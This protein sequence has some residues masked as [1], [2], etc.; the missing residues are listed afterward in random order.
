[1]STEDME[2]NN[3][4]NKT[5]RTWPRFLVIQSTNDTN[6]AKTSPFLI[7]K[8][9]AGLAG[10]PKSVKKMRNG[11][12]LVECAKESHASSLLKSTTL[13]NIPIKVAPHNSLNSSRGVIRSQ[14]LEGS[15]EEEMLENLASQGVTY[16]KRISI[17]RNGN[18]I[19]TNTYILTFDKP[20]LP[21]MIKAGFLA[22]TV[23]PYIPNPLRCFHC[24]RFGHS[25][26]VCKGKATCARCGQ[27]GHESTSCQLDHCCINCKGSHF[28]Y[29][30]ECP[31]WKKE[32]QVQ[33]VKTEKN[34][35]YPEARKLVEAATPTFA[36][37]FANAVKP[38]TASIACQTPA[39]FPATTESS[40][41]KK[42]PIPPKPVNV[43]LSTQ[44][45]NKSGETENEEIVPPTPQPNGGNPPKANKTKERSDKDASRKLNTFRSRKGDEDPVG[46]YNRFG[47]QDNLMDVV[48]EVHDPKQ[49]HRSPVKPP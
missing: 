9:L 34:I 42:P 36:M 11:T 23:T 38:K 18:I 49:H 15:S 41:Q 5:S 2:I 16:V 27:D 39:E 12:L 30:R 7:S 25:K 43:S 37:S 8:G 47:I 45:A 21:K 28:A 13:A 3:I 32:K 29:S 40:S 48:V 31:I 10:E 24:Q 19:Q 44:T 17:R 26:N 46:T 1:M 35:P 33:Q 6:L 4:P 14:D 20:D 22:I